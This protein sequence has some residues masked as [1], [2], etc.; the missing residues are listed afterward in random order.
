MGGNLK[1]FESSSTA[2]KMR[3]SRIT[4]A[5]LSSYAIIAQLYDLYRVSVSVRSICGAA[6]LSAH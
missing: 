4:R 6:L 1:A 3:F 2:A 5:P